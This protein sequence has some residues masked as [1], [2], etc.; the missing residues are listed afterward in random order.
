MKFIEWLFRLPRRIGEAEF[1]QVS[2]VI[3]GALVLWA[4]FVWFAVRGPQLLALVPL[5]IGLYAVYYAEERS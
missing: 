3:V 1:F 2:F 5:F 4:S